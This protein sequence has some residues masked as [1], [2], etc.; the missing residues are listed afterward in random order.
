MGPA[1]AKSQKCGRS[2]GRVCC[3]YCSAP[4][5]GSAF[6]PEAQPGPAQSMELASLAGGTHAATLFC[7]EEREVVRA[8]G[9]A[10]RPAKGNALVRAM[11]SECFC[12]PDGPTILLEEEEGGWAVGPTVLGRSDVLPAALPFFAWMNRRPFRGRNPLQGPTSS[13]I[14]SPRR[15]PQHGNHRIDRTLQRI[16]LPLR[17]PARPVAVQAPQRRRFHRT[18]RIERLQHGIMRP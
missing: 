1:C 7:A 5:C 2:I 12:R 15:P 8:E 14:L 3:Q 10:V 16:V 11:P 4:K 17:L 13:I 9:P 18:L 6:G